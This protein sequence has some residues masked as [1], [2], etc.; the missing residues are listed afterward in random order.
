[1]KMRKNNDTKTRKKRNGPK[2][3]AKMLKKKRRKGP[4]SMEEG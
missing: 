2:K 3:C 1:M 4:R